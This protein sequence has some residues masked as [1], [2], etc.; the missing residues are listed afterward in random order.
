MLASPRQLSL[1]SQD[2]AA[3]TVIVATLDRKGAAMLQSPPLPSR[4]PLRQHQSEPFLTLARCV[5]RQ[6]PFRDQHGQR[7]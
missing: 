5:L 1:P 7:R 6:V 2:I 3:R 4:A